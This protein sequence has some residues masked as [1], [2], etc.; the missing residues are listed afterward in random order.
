MKLDP[1]DRGNIGQ[2][3]V[4][5]QPSAADPAT[6]PHFQSR[7]EPGL[8]WLVTREAIAILLI[9]PDGQIV[10]ASPGAC[11]VCRG[12]EA[13]IMQAGLYGLG[14]GTDERSRAIIQD[15]VA[16]HNATAEVPVYCLDGQTRGVIA[17]AFT[18]P[19]S[20]RPDTPP[21]TMLRLEA[22]DRQHTMLHQLRSDEERYRTSLEAAGIGTWD[23]D[24]RKNETRR[25]LLHDQC[26]GYQTLLEHWG[27]D[28][29]LDHVVPEDRDRVDRTYRAAMAGGAEYDLEFRVAW[30]DGSIHWLWSKGRFYLDDQG[31]PARAA[32]IQADVTERY[33]AQADLRLAAMAID[34][35]PNG[36]T[37]ADAQLPDTPLIRVNP[38]YELLTGYPADEIVGR[39]CR[40]LQGSETNQPGLVEVRKALRDGTDAEVVLRN[41]RKDGT[42][43]WNRL[44]LCAVR[45]QSGTVTHF[46]GIQTDVTADIESRNALQYQASHDF[47]T[48]VYNRQVF[49][50]KLERSLA[51]AR[52]SGQIIAVLFIDIDHFKR[53]NDSLNHS[54]GDEVL[55]AIADRLVQGLFNTTLVGRVGGDEFAVVMENVIDHGHVVTLVNTLIDKLS[56]P[57]PLAQNLVVPTVSIGIALYPDHGNTPSELIKAADMAMYEAK[58]CGRATFRIH[59]HRQGVHADTSLAFE[60]RLRMALKNDEITLYYQPQFDLPSGRLVGFEALLRWLPP[61]E[62]P[63]PP[64][65]FVEAAEHSGFIAILGNWVITEACRQARAWRDAGYAP[66]PIAIN[67][68]AMQFRRGDLTDVIFEQLRA[69]DLPG[70]A[71][72]VEMTETIAMDDTDTI[73]ETMMALKNAGITLAIDDFGTGFSSLSYLRNF[74][75]DRLKID[76]AF[77]MNALSRSGDAAI[78]KVVILLAR[79]FGCR[80]IA[81]GVEDVQTL[82]YLRKQGCDEVQGYYLS[83]PLPATA[84]TQFM[85]PA[86]PHSSATP[87][88]D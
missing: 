14:L 2:N 4:A 72:E 57:M 77:V 54:A 15:P 38:A 6:C 58:R 41:F 40:F 74:P 67:V 63:I 52:A 86:T 83:H 82:E 1:T 43:F 29:F 65:V 34:A 87:E 12:S 53:F 3:A 48:G 22:L 39:N 23:M 9:D 13:Q 10:G 17:S 69:F 32:G 42:P 66:V 79:S 27:Y 45:N 5:N 25:S 61:G 11:R 46:V 56:E 64:A 35:S 8:H 75:V 80:V 24:I 33:T 49:E 36:I 88:P 16:D 78:C 84:A 44:K 76:R 73:I 62:A 19:A 31:R 51:R 81:E 47:L 55:K 70:D 60:E 68:S 21:L 50:E 28:V 71:L 7:V 30:P 20:Q 18:P 59:E 37:V 85:T 26:F